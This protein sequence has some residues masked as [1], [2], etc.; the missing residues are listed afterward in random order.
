MLNLMKNWRIKLAKPTLE[1]FTNQLVYRL[2]LYEHLVMAQQILEKRP[3]NRVNIASGKDM[4]ETGYDLMLFLSQEIT[5]ICKVMLQMFSKEQLG[6]LYQLIV[7][8]VADLNNNP[9]NNTTIHRTD[10]KVH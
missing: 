3:D 7:D 4:L 6:D 5:G 2:G 1:D 8:T 10:G 9:P